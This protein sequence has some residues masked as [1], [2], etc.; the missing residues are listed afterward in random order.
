MTRAPSAVL[1]V[2][3]AALAL[4]LLL[5]PEASTPP[6]PAA[7][8]EDMEAVERTGGAG[9]A[10]ADAEPAAAFAVIGRVLGSGRRPAAGADVELFLD[11]RRIAAASTAADGAFRLPVRAR[12]DDP[13]ATLVVRAH[14]EAGRDA[15]ARVFGERPRTEDLDAG[16]LVLG[17]GEA[18]DVLVTASNRPVA[19]ARVDLLGSG[20]LEG[21]L[22]S[23][24]AD[25]DGRASFPGLPPRLFRV[26]AWADGFAATSVPVGLPR[27]T[28]GPVRVELEPARTVT[29]EVVSA[30]DERPV[31]GVRVRVVLLEIGPKRRSG[32]AHHPTLDIP[33]TD[34]T[35]RTQIDGLGRDPALHLGVE[36]RGF[37]VLGKYPGRGWL[38]CPSKYVP[39]PPGDDLV[40]VVLPAGRRVAWPLVAGDVPVPPDGTPIGV[41][42][43]PGSRFHPAGADHGRIE[44]GR[45][46]VEG[47]DDRAVDAIA[48]APDG[49]LARITADAGA[50]EGPGIAFCRPR[51]F[52]IV[53]SHPD[54]SPAPDRWVSLLDRD[55][56]EWTD[57]KGRAT[58]RGLVAEDCTFVVAGHDGHIGKAY[59][60]NGDVSLAVTVPPL[61]EPPPV[62]ALRIRVRIGGQSRLPDEYT[63]CCGPGAPDVTVTREDPEAGVIHTT[64]RASGAPRPGAECRFL[65]RGHAPAPI[66]LAPGSEEITIDLE[67]AGSLFVLILEAPGVRVGKTVLSRVERFDETA[68]DWLRV[69]ATR[70]DPRPLSP[71][72]FG[73]A[74]LLHD[75]RPGRYR[76]RD[77]RSGLVSDEVTVSAGPTP[78]RLVFDARP[79]RDVAGV[80]LGPGGTD[81]SGAYVEVVTPGDAAPKKIDVAPDGSFSFSW[82]SGADPVRLTPRHPSL[83]PDPVRGSARLESPRSD[84]RLEMVPAGVI[85]VAVELDG[86]MRLSPDPQVLLLRDPGDREP[87]FMLPARLTEEAPG[88]WRLR[89]AAAA[90]GR[91]T[92][93]CDLSG[94]HVPLVI[95][96]VETGAGDRDLGARKL[97]RGSRIRAAAA[98]G[99]KEAMLMMRAESVE[100]PPFRRSG[101]AEAGEE[102][103]ITG[104][105]AGR[106]RVRGG[107]LSLSRP[108]PTLDEEIEVDGHS[109]YERTIVLER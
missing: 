23:A 38:P 37:A 74:W 26:V 22:A 44:G 59:L 45:L 88:R 72:L 62:H 89:F 40:R 8:G 99:G 4:W 95:R 63:I 93:W 100:G 94:R 66:P 49:S 15:V 36:A 31:A 48:T 43:T 68:G 90:P 10:D 20:R 2:A 34:E 85:T 58:F 107:R 41:R 108:P 84:V 13:S 1:A 5:R 73:E 101:S 12:I 17:E 6:G 82:T 79:S 30:P 46:V 25:A 76:V 92:L 109:T 57:G 67:P 29:V 27:A 105:P 96:D 47:F 91:F 51:R 64:W 69:S 39:I 9:A 83:S 11:G 33:P 24:T 42:P 106:Y 19:G 32:H 14:D 55:G 102:V 53:L 52:E 50:A 28:R 65:A 3:I 80:L 77:A 71:P 86:A 35:G 61:W 60:K 56:S 103:E 18:I 97:G 54:G 98:G 104:L 81:W 21:L 75:L 7:R 78:A 70:D 16:T 87:A